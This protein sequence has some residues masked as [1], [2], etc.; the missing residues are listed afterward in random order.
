M[1]NSFFKIAINN[2]VEN[3]VRL[4]I[5]RGDNINARDADGMTPLMIAAL[6]NR[7]EI[8]KLLLS[9]GA[10]PLLFDSSGRDAQLIAKVSNSREAL[11]VIENFLA[12][13]KKNKS[14]ENNKNNLIIFEDKEE[15]K[16]DFD[17]WE[18]EPEINTPVGD[19]RAVASASKIQNEISVHAP[20][21]F[22]ENW[23][24][25]ELFLPEKS[26]PI[27]KIH[28][29]EKLQKLR[30]L[31]LEGLREGGIAEEY[32]DYISLNDDDSFNQEEERIIKIA[33]SSLGIKIYQR[34]QKYLDV[35]KF[36]FNFLENQE[37]ETEENIIDEAMYFIDSIKN[38]NGDPQKLF[39]K[40]LL[41]TSL[42]D[43]SEE[44]EFFQ[45]MEESIEKAINA[46]SFSESGIK[47]IINSAK[48]IEKGIK[49][50]SWMSGKS[51]DEISELDIDQIDVNN[52]NN[53]QE[54]S[55]DDS[56]KFQNS[57]TDNKSENKIS[58]FIKNIKE[59][60]ILTH[61]NIIENQVLIS[62]QL[63]LLN[64]NGLFLL[65]LNDENKIQEKD[66]S[67]EFNIRI[68]DFKN[69][70]DKIISSNLK[71]VHSV[72][73]KYLYTNAPLIDLIQEGNIGLIRAIDGF[74]WKKGFKLSTY[75][76]WWIRQRITRYLADKEKLIRVP[77]H[78]FEKI[79][80]IK[81]YIRTYEFKNN[82]KPSIEKISKAFNMPISKASIYFHSIDD[83]ISFEDIN[84]DD[85]IADNLLEEFFIKDPREINEEID[86]SLA[87]R[88]AI[89]ILTP[90]AQK[91]I[92]MRFGI[93]ISEE[94]TLDEIGGLMGV[95][96]ERIRQIESKSLKLL[97]RNLT[98]KEL[99]DSLNNRNPYS[100]VSIENNNVEVSELVIK[101][102]VD[103]VIKEK[104]IKDSNENKR[105]KKSQTK[106]DTVVN[107][108]NQQEK[109][110]QP[111][112]PKPVEDVINKALV[113]G[114]NVEFDRDNFDKEI[115]IDF[116]NLKISPD[117]SFIRKLINLGFKFWSGK[118]YWQ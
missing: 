90:K 118:W 107:K 114:A 116:T 79:Q 17:A 68:Q 75:A 39:Q 101:S 67:S 34:E 113:M 76:I 102:S 96:R 106:N 84:I 9:E 110:F 14:L 30:A 86:F 100:Q 40:L 77:V 60:E 6:K 97:F 63:K 37:N 104:N 21:D 54:F 11:L 65:S 74:E 45:K 7:S 42:F 81:I 26:A 15:K 47:F 51:R 56:L 25:S 4:H 24:T 112:I 38:N 49:P 61:S 94:M 41:K 72:A 62:N 50:L 71:L 85:L 111:K 88:N 59:I 48:D 103:R 5:E 89:Q 109:I 87:I 57:Y 44:I 117:R 28:V 80:N 2:G 55:E 91:I 95:T 27:F 66:I 32:I 64:L 70:R 31:I 23:D 52:L 35:K 10:D 43:S 92:R 98:I 19:L 53:D 36:K 83:P 13:F 33:L 46:L 3:S 29:A 18:V 69:F 99:S 8:C 16:L 93:E 73:K 108:N 82:K 22:S 58:E 78:A 115:W 12:D 1:L 20:I 105:I